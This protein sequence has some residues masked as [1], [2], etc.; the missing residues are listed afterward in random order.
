[1]HGIQPSCKG[2]LPSAL[3]LVLMF[4]TGDSQLMLRLACPALQITYSG[5]EKCLPAISSQDPAVAAARQQITAILQQNAQLPEQLCSDFSA[6]FGEL[7]AVD[8]TEFLEVIGCK[9]SKALVSSLLELPAFLQRSCCL[10]LRT[11]RLPY[12]AAAFVSCCHGQAERAQD[13]DGALQGWAAANHSLEET[14]AEIKTLAA[15]ALAAQSA[16]APRI[17]FCLY[18]VSEPVPRHALSSMPQLSLSGSKAYCFL[19]ASLPVCA[20]HLWL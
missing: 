3:L 12:Q 19:E 14:D 20:E 17:S 6:Q 10:D 5:Q 1:M 7:A 8:E 13:K 9:C 2:P 16:A 18:Q 11:Q 4:L 15:M